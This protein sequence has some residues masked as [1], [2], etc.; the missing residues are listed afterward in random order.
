MNGQLSDLYVDDDGYIC[1]EHTIDRNIAFT[2]TLHNLGWEVYL[3]EVCIY[4]FD[5]IQYGLNYPS[6]K[7]FKVVENMI[8]HFRYTE[9]GMWEISWMSAEQFCRKHL[10]FDE[11]EDALT[12]YQN[13]EK[14]GEI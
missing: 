8:S 1:I 11:F 14:E 13:L 9:F 7:M 3:G 4:D 12:A 6:Q 2:W 10:Q 5:K